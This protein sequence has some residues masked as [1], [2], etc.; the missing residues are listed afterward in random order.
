M[1]NTPVS[2]ASNN[3]FSQYWASYNTWNDIINALTKTLPAASVLSIKALSPVTFKPLT[4]Y[5]A[6]GYAGIPSYSL[7]D[8]IIRPFSQY[9]Q[10]DGFTQNSGK[11]KYVNAGDFTTSTFG[12]IRTGYTLASL[13]LNIYISSI[14]TKSLIKDERFNNNLSIYSSVIKQ[15]VKSLIWE[16]ILMITYDFRKS[17][18]KREV[19]SDNIFISINAIPTTRPTYWAAYNK[20]GDMINGEWAA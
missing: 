6:Y 15:L 14:F 20:W 10:G 1:I 4:T 18:N 8:N 17:T 11:Y 9:M 2:I 13:N 19:F 3:N 16:D 7:N 12:Y 5:Y